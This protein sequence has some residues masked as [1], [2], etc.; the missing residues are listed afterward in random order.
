ME[1]SFQNLK[2]S[3]LSKKIFSY[4]QVLKTM[5]SIITPNRISI[6]LFGYI[7]AS[8]KKLVHENSYVLNEKCQKTKDFAKFLR[9]FKIYLVAGITKSKT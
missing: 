4:F 5:C 3:L 1:K 9:M 2:S 7:F 6:T 8:Q